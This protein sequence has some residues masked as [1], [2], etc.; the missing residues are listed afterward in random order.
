MNKQTIEIRKG[1]H[2]FKYS[3]CN[4][5]GIWIF[6]ISKI[7]DA[8]KRYKQEIKSG[9]IVLVRNLNAEPDLSEHKM[10]LENLNRLMKSF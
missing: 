1:I 8:T 3:V 9:E 7:S 10:I 4:N 5:Q 6:N 2:G